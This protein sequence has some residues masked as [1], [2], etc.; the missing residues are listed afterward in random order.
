MPE[1]DQSS[2]SD[3]QLVFGDCQLGQMGKIPA[4]TT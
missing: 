2:A 1:E 3:E 4:A